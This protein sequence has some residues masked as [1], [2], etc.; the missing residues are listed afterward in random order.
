MSTTQKVTPSKSQTAQGATQPKSQTAYGET[1]PK[2]QTAYGRAQPDTQ[3]YSPETAQRLIWILLEGHASRVSEATVAL[4]RSMGLS[5]DELVNVRRGALLHDVG[6]LE[7]SEE[8]VYNDGPLS[9]DEWQ[10]MRHHPD[11]AVQMLSA[12]PDLQPALTIPYCHH[13][14][15]NGT[16]YPRGLK[17]EE[18]PLEARIFKVV[19]VWDALTSDRIYREAW[20]KQDVVNYIRERR[21]TEFDPEVVD[22]FLAHY[23]EIP[24]LTEKAAAP[25]KPMRHI[26]F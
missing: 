15:W 1:Q 3:Q 6:K 5:S 11:S 24:A 21:G 9:E 26:G 8:I 14:N 25:P 20:P 10:A 18:I 4:A 2:A 17:G 13:E 19:D 22:F 12:I 23:E 7:L 16:G